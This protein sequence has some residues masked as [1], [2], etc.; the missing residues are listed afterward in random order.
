MGLAMSRKIVTRTDVYSFKVAILFFYESAVGAK[1]FENDQNRSW[2]WRERS[3]A[4]LQERSLPKLVLDV[5]VSRNA[6]TVTNIVTK[7]Q[8]NTEESKRYYQMWDLVCTTL[9]SPTLTQT[10]A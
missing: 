1:G 3:R 7:K 4:L 5:T 6:T 9:H 2:S 8:T 10:L